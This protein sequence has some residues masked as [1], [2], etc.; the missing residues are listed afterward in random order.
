M[1]P[2]FDFI[3]AVN[4]TN[5]ELNSTRED[6]KKLLSIHIWVDSKLELGGTSR[7][8]ELYYYN[9]TSYKAEKIMRENDI[10]PPVTHVYSI[11]NNGPSDIKEAEM[12]FVWPYATM[13]GRDLLYL[14]EEHQTLGNIKCDT[15]F[16]NYKGYEVFNIKYN[17]YQIVFLA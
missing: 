14:L 1:Q 5:E 4:S 10:G 3:M 7:P 9:L 11:R 17:I 2:S 6:N 12:F 8:T 13:D 15:S 16:V